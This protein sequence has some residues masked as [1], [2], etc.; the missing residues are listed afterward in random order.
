[1]QTP[2]QQIKITHGNKTMS[3]ISSKQDNKGVAKINAADRVRP[4]NPK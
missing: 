2:P 3:R 1:M 4:D